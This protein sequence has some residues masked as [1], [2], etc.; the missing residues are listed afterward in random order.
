MLGTDVDRPRQQYVN[1]LHL[2]IIEDMAHDIA[3]MT[4]IYQNLSI[5]ARTFPGLWRLANWCAVFSSIACR[6][7]IF[8]DRTRIIFGTLLYRY[9][10]VLGPHIWR[11]LR[12]NTF[13][14]LSKSEKESDSNVSELA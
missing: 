11:E 3:N 6:P 1:D 5:F 2:S 9:F 7:L 13:V 4:G 10:F 14:P 12:H 8:S